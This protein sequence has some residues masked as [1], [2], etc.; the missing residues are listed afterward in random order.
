MA[1][2]R[3]ERTGAVVAGAW[4]LTVFGI[5]GIFAAMCRKFL[6]EA[7]GKVVILESHESPAR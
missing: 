4:T 1:G 5:H 2:R 6:Q 7:A 3:A